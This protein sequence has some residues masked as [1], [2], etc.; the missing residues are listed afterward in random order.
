[1]LRP[2][3][4]WNLLWHRKLRQ[5]ERNKLQEHPQITGAVARHNL[6]GHSL[7]QQRH[8]APLAMTERLYRALRWTKQG[9]LPWLLLGLLVCAPIVRAQIVGFDRQAVEI[10]GTVFVEGRNRPIGGA[11][12]NIRS[13]TGGFFTSVLTDWNGHFQVR[14]LNS[15][16]YEIVVEEA[17]YEPTRETLQLI[18]GPSP[19]LELHLKAGNSSPVRWTDY[20][21]SV[22]ELRIPV[23]ARNAFEQGLERLAKNDAD[24]SRT[25]FL[26]ATATF[27]DYYEAYYHMGVADLR[28]GREE[29]AVQAFQKAIDLS[30]GR[31]AWAQFGLG[32]LLCRR[33]E[34]AEAETVIREGLEVDGRSATG[35]LFLSVALFH[36]NRLEAAER[37]AREAL[38]RKPGFASAYLMLAEVHAR[39]AEYGMELHDL[40][41]YLKLES[42][43]T[44]STRVREVRES[45]WRIVFRA[46]DEE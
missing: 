11:I 29:E 14:G 27:P 44:A 19:P 6:R 43:G 3:E 2:L 32:L 18:G 12:V 20:S 45:V 33:G 16:E 8:N 10:F 38:L 26:R 5:A 35:H 13:L 31:Y 7:C 24:G 15:G 36:L 37:S 28:L 9:V 34:Y 42:D 30:G 1:M 40:D 25:Q 22:R 23:K 21:V 46:K 17:G 39:R 4:H 41:A